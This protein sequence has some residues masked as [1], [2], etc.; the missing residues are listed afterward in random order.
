VGKDLSP[1][2]AQRDELVRHREAIEG[3][4]R[5]VVRQ[6]RWR[7][8]LDRRHADAA[9]M[10]ERI[11]E[12]RKRIDDLRESRPDRAAVTEDLTQRFAELLTAFGFPK[13]DEPQPPTLNEK[14]VPYVRGNRYTDIGSTG[15]LTLI[16]LAW[17]LTIFERAVEQ[18][19]PHPGFLLVDSPQKNL[20]PETAAGEADEF[21][22][23]AIPRRV[24]EHI[25]NWS[26]G[27]G[28]SAQIIVV[29]NSPPDNA[30]DH[31]VVRYSG[32][33]DEPPYGL[34]EDETG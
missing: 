30:D 34:I 10:Q 1:F 27:M 8:G 14:F 20:K 18:G 13:L 5:E 15:A 12:L 4:Q 2:L 7:D 11:T 6:V 28:K 26:T 24:W 17:Q 3:Q 21:A 9:H 33:V 16:A 22:D 32:R 25:V 31:V 29:D 19:D 23:P